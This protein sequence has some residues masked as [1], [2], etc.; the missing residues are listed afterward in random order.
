[1]KKSCVRVLAVAAILGLA[2]G[3]SLADTRIE[4]SLDLSPGGMFVL[5]SEGGTVKLTGSSDSGVRIVITSKRDDL[6]S[7]A[8]FTFEGGSEMARV[9]MKR[10]KTGG[11]NRGLSLAYEIEV[12]NATQLD[13]RTSGGSIS[14]LETRGEAKL[15][16][17]GGSIKVKALEGPLNASTSGGSITLGDI[18]GDAKVSTSGGS[19][20]GS[21]VEGRLDAGTSGGS[22]SLEGVTG[23]L[24]AE[25]SGGS[26]QIADAGGV[27]NASTSGGSLTV[28]FAPG[29]HAG[30]SLQTSGGGIRVKID[31]TANLD[32]DAH[33]SGGSVKTDMPVTVVGNLSKN[34]LKGAMGSGGA[35]LRLRT[36]GGSIRIEGM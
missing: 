7:L 23:D 33:C 27:V 29:N 20:R 16:T 4:K 10:V 9:T 31:E 17:S 36:S 18:V 28:A 21:H 5:D 1:M 15:R 34:T 6:E 2:A 35:T 30:G 8:N 22:I 14:T 12:P 19:I 13:I 24:D 32:L 25:T 26:I 11:W 3:C